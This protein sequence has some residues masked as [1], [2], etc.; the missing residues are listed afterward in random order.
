LTPATLG[1]DTITDG[2]DVSHSNELADADDLSPIQSSGDVTVT[3]TQAGK[4]NDGEFLTNSGGNLTGGTVETEPNIPNWELDGTINSYSSSTTYTINDTFADYYHFKGVA[5]SANSTNTIGLRFND[6]GGNLAYLELRDTSQTTNADY[7]PVARAPDDG[8]V[9]FEFSF[10]SP[11]PPNNRAVFT[12][13]LYTTET[14]AQ[15]GEEPFLD[16]SLDFIT[17][18]ATNGL[19]TIEIEGNIYAITL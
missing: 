10:F 16:A 17:L 2:A 12:N 6:K 14:V 18:A 4:L 9:A 3:D 8:Y 1:A 11:D 19:T 5:K 13:K 15:Y 7:I